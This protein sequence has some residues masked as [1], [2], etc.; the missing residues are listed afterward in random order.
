MLTVEQIALLVAA[1]AAYLAAGLLP[2]LLRRQGP[3]VARVARAANV[4]GLLL[5]LQ[6]LIWHSLAQEQPWRP[7]ADNFEAL[8]GIAI[9]VS[10]FLLY[11]Q[12]RHPVGSI[13]F[14]LLPIIIG[15][16]LL[17]GFFGQ[18]VHQQYLTTAWSVVHRVT[19]FLGTA[20]F[21]V[22]AA[23]GALYLRADWALRSKRLDVIAP[24]TSLE[25]LS[26]LNYSS[27][28]LGFAL[29][30]VGCITGFVWMRHIQEPLYSSPQLLTSSKINF[31]IAAWI[32]YAIVL[33]T[34]IT[35]RLRGRRNAWLSVAG[36]AFLLL[37]I[38][39]VIAMPGEGR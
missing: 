28:T 17:A 35:P 2:W 24:T 7:L 21:A 4:V 27:V 23:T 1:M 36:F 12:F 19:T 29:F 26:R 11:L 25:R 34:P 5:S 38:V 14:F 20:A 18:L 30:T 3:A 8:L 9:L 13:E 33:H 10:A 31:A 16:L 15:L 6:L 32:V 39:A 22:A 37:S